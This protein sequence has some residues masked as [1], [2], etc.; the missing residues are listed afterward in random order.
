MT[1]MNL[2]PEL[3]PLDTMNSS[4]LWLTGTILG[5]ELRDL[6][7]MNCLRLLMT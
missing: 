2:E 7:S 5:H 6:G 1:L 3:N 4:G